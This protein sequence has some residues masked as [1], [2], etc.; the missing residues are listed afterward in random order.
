MN[1]TIW[2][3]VGLIS[4]LLTAGAISLGVSEETAGQSASTGTDGPALS[5]SFEPLGNEAT[6]SAESTSDKSA[7]TTASDSEQSVADTSQMNQSEDSPDASAKINVEGPV[8]EKIDL[9]KSAGQKQP[10]IESEPA[11]AAGV[12]GDDKSGEISKVGKPA[13]ETPKQ[14]EQPAAA[15]PPKPKRELNPALAALR[16]K[17]RKTLGVYYKM[18]FNTR[19]NTADEIIDCCLAFGCEAEISL[20]DAGGEKRANGITCLCWNYPCGGYAP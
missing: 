18:P 1:K 16:D 5:G 8:Q 20:I 12:S 6:E 10:A 4:L 19:Q 11:K 3:G 13:A 15:E 2:I 7:S 17:V 14:S 9:E